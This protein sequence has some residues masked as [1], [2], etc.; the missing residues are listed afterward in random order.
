MALA[1]ALVTVHVAP[2]HRGAWPIVTR[3]LRRAGVGLERLHSGHVDDSVA[4]PLL[5]VAAIG[6]AVLVP[7][8]G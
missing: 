6:A 5:G 1:V 4:W 2:R 3:A 7:V 8:R